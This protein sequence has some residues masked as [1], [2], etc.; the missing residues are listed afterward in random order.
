MTDKL[1]TAAIQ[2]RMEALA[3]FTPGPWGTETDLPYNT[4][5]RVSGADGSLICECGNV[6][7]D[8]D[9]WESDARLI[10]AAPDMHEA[11]TALSERCRVLEEALS[12]LELAC[13]QLASTRTHEV[14]LAMIDSGQ[15]DALLS[16][17]ARRQAARAAL[18]QKEGK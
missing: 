2:T 7:T 14:Y 9:Q 5:P 8:Q 13:D 3:G 11:I 10:A 1:D 12:G 6:S 18:A 4:M 16:L 17:D 15:A